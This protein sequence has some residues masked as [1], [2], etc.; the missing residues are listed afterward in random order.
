[1]SIGYNKHLLIT[2]IF[3]MP[4]FSPLHIYSKE[5]LLEQPSTK[6][7]YNEVTIVVIAPIMHSYIIS[8]H[9]PPCTT[10]PTP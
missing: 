3:V 4:W 2:S 7:D 1:M 6:L 5:T 9:S 10:V 8:P